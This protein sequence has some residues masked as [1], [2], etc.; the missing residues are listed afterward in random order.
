MLSK[1]EAFKMILDKIFEDTTSSMD[2]QELIK[3]YVDD[4]L[5]T[6][7]PTIIHDEPISPD[8]IKL[9]VKE[10]PKPTK[11]KLEPT[12]R[13]EYPKTYTKTL[14]WKLFNDGTVGTKNRKNGQ[15]ES[16]QLMRVFEQCKIPFTNTECTRNVN[17]LKKNGFNQITGMRL[18]Y[19]LQNQLS[20]ESGSLLDI[21]YDIYCHDFEV[22]AYVLFGVQNNQITINNV[23]T[24][25]KPFEVNQKFD[26]LKSYADVKVG[27]V[28]LMKEIPN[29]DKK[30][31]FIILKNYGNNSLLELL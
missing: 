17:I 8:S 15:Y 10:T 9:T 30:Y 4:Y 3:E 5:N 23:E 29:R 26:E 25:I 18:L 6:Q 28:K 24:G 1:K 20:S 19:N 31:W 16:Y 7:E 21:L 13:Y 14:D 22:P 2:L 11:T 27:I 12:A